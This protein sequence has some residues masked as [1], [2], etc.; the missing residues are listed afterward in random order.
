M[1]KERKLGIEMWTNIRGM[2][3]ASDG[4][5]PESISYYKEMFCVEHGLEWTGSCWFCQYIRDCGKCPLKSCK[6]GSYYAIVVDSLM[7]TDVR[8]AACN[9]IIKALGGKA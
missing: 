8:V 6:L 9:A 1:T 2:L 5:I 3:S 4:Q 7:D